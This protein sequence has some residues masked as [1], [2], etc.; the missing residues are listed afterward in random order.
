M[1]LCAHHPSPVGGPENQNRSLSIRR[2]SRLRIV[3]VRRIDGLGRHWRAQA[4]RHHSSW[5]HLQSLS[6][7]WPDWPSA[8]GTHRR[9]AGQSRKYCACFVKNKGN[10]E[11][12]MSTN[13]SATN[14]AELT[15]LRELSARIGNDPLLTQASTGNSSI[16]LDGVLWIKASGKWMA[17]A[18]R[19]DILIPLNLADVRKRVKQKVDPADRVLR[20]FHRDRDARDSAAPGR[21]SRTLR[22]HD[23]LGGTSRRTCS[24]ATPNGRP[25]LAM[26]PVR[27]FGPA[28]RAGDRKGPYLPSR[29]PM[30]SYWATTVWFSEETIAVLSKIFYSRCSDAWPLAPGRR[31]RPT[32]LCW[33]RLPMV[34]HGI[35][36]MTMKCM[37]SPRTQSLER[38]FPEV[39]SILATRFFRPRV[40]QRCSARFLAPIPRTNRR[41]A[42]VLSPS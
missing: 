15:R 20:C 23:R 32:T 30:S 8:A 5:G 9:A 42:T 14:Q 25:T 19:E 21:S 33:P 35:C 13:T 7:N 36:Q 29:T 37:L 31:T 4:G 2:K 1:Y 12:C 3:R 39:S 24:T 40:P 10:L 27:A 41:V 16:K 17:D 22:E 34:H 26:D 6:Q 11:E 18:L 38:F 28:P